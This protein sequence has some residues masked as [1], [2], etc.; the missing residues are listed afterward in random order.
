LAEPEFDLDYSIHDFEVEH[1]P[2]STYLFQQIED[3]MVRE[4]AVPGGRTLDVAC[5]I[6]RLTARFKESGGQGWGIEP[7]DEMLGLSRLIVP[8]DAVILTRGVAETMPFRNGSFDRIVCQGALDHFV[9]PHAFMAEAARI[10]KQDGRVILALANYDSLSCRLG[11]PLQKTYWRLRN[12]QPEGRP[13]WQT[14]DDHFHRGTLDFVRRL[15]GS[16]LVLDQSYG[17]SLFWLFPAWG[18]VLARLPDAAGNTLLG[19]LNRLANGRPQLSDMI[20]SV[21]K[22]PSR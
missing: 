17:L 21:W 10:I 16:E 19:V 20:V 7:S 11:R 1:L 3:A 15:G 9:E 22:K 14:P 12:R 4:G 2:D 18:Q 6:G 13:Y 5:G 8:R